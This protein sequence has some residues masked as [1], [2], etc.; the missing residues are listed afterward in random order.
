MG[1]DQQCMRRP[2]INNSERGDAVYEP[3]AGSGT[4]PIA[5]ESV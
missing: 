1:A 3:F 2:M 5:A 4:T